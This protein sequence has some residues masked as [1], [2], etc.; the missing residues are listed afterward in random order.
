MRVWGARCNGGEGTSLPCMPAVGFYANPIWILYVRLLD[1]TASSIEP[2]AARATRRRR[3][4]NDLQLQR[5]LS[6]PSLALLRLALASPVVSPRELAHPDPPAYALRP[7]H[8]PPARSA[9]ASLSL[10]SG[11]RQVIATFSAAACG[12]V[13]YFRIRKLLLEHERSPDTVPFPEGAARHASP[14]SA[15]VASAAAAAITQRV[16]A[17]QRSRAWRPPP[18]R[19]PSCRRIASADC[20]RAIPACGPMPDAHEESARCSPLQPSLVWRA[21]A[22]AVV[23]CRT[24]HPWSFGRESSAPDPSVCRRVGS[25]V[26][27][28]VLFA[29]S[30]CWIGG[31]Q[32]I[33]HSKTLAELFD[34]MGGG[35]VTL[36]DLLGDWLFWSELLIT[37]VGGPSSSNQ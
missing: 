22:C 26:S 21:R 20:R 36:I 5:R 11:R 31:A 12:W 32:M 28:P 27:L 3:I 33:V 14:H 19:Q 4:A 29:L 9:P 7:C 34:L 2:H 10:R 16:A 18:P 13:V 37:A 1:R 23:S 6:S 24:A 17:V 35:E 30:S 25:D 15:V 8:C